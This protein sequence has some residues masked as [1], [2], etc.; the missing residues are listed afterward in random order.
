MRTCGIRRL[1]DVG[2]VLVKPGCEFELLRRCFEE[3]CDLRHVHATLRPASRDLEVHRNAVQ[4]VADVVREL[5]QVARLFA[6]AHRRQSLRS[7][8]SGA[9]STTARSGCGIS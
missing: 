3:R 1:R 6:L 2:V 8:S 5:A 4:C 7:A 9:A